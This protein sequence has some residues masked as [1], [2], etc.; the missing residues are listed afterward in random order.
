MGDL[1]L[2]AA[3]GGQLDDQHRGEHHQTA[4]HHP[5]RRALAT[6]QHRGVVPDFDRA[7]V[8]ADGVAVARAPSGTTLVFVDGGSRTLR[9]FP[10]RGVA[11]GGGAGVTRRR[12]T[13]FYPANGATILAGSIDA[14]R[15]VELSSPPR[16]PWLLLLD[17]EPASG[18]SHRGSA[19]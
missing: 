7:L 5:D 19:G 6:E 16:G 2:D 18:V 14:R 3:P 11:A 9:I 8:S 4:D 17:D 10:A 12:V 1:G 13:W 15:V